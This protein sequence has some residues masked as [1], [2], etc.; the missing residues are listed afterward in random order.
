MRYRLGLFAVLLFAFVTFVTRDAFAQERTIRGTV[1][2]DVTGEPVSFVQVSVKGTTIGTVGGEDGT[3]TLRGAP[4]GAVTLVVQRIGYKSQEITVAADEAAVTVALVTDYL[5][6]EELI[7]TG[8]ATAIEREIAPNAVEHVSGERVNELPQQTIDQALQGRV[9][10]AV[11]ARNQG[12]PGGGLQV[13][14]RGSSSINAAAEPLYVVDGVLVSNA[15]IPSNQNVLT[16]ASGGSNPSLDQDV[17]QNRIADLNMQDIESI[18]ILKGASAAAIYGSKASNGVVIITTKRGRV[19]PAQVNASFQGGFFDLRS[20]IGARTFETQEE[21]ETA[22]GANAAQFFQPGRTFD[23]EGLLGGRNEF[24]WEASG[25]V[26][27]GAEGGLSYFGSALWKDD[28][29]IIQNTGFEKQSAR[30]NL[31][32]QLGD[33]RA[34]ISLNMNVIHSDAARSITN[35][36]NS[37]AVSHFMVLP[38]TPNFIDLRQRPDG[39]WPINVF[40]PGGVN[41]LQTAALLENDEIVWRMIASANL[42]VDVLRGEKNSF[43]IIAPLGVDFFNQRNRIFSP[44]SLN[45]ES[46]DGQLGTSLLSNTDNINLNM[47][48]NGIW[49][50]QASGGT[51]F[52]TAVGLQFERRE[53]DTSRLVGENLTG[54]KNK[55]DAATLVQIRENKVEVEDFGFY[56]QEEILGFN[57]R[58]LLTGMVR[59]DQSSADGNPDKVFI[60][61]K[62]ATS[63]RIPDAP[64]FLDNVKFRG[65][66]GQTGNQPLC[67]LEDGCQKFTSLRLDQNIEGIPGINLENTVGDPN[68]DPERMSE[69]EGG[70][71]LSAYNGRATLE[72]TGYGQIITNLILQRQIAEST[73]FNDLFFNGGKLRNLG[74][75]ASLG[76]TPVTSRNLTWVSR[77]SFFLNRSKL[78]D[79][80]VPPFRTIGFGLDLGQGFIME[81][82]SITQIA[83]TDPACTAFKEPF[84]NCLQEGLARNGDQNPDFTLNFSNDITLGD[85]RFF[86]LFE[87]R[88]GQDVINLT[89]LLY[90]LVGQNSPDFPVGW[91]FGRLGEFNERPARECHPDCNAA[92]RVLGFLNGSALPYTQPGSFLKARE[93][94]VSYSLPEKVTSKLFGG[95]F[96]RVRLRA[97]ARDLFAITNYDGLDPEVSNFGNQQVSRSIDVAPFPPSRSFFFGVDVGL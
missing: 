42:D 80:P 15:A 93:I 74:F 96:N 51:T 3:F 38:G 21:A 1:T 50:Y 18:E 69:F 63:Y 84:N 30:I 58:F 47:G 61:P 85:F 33:R 78:L 36:G 91:N 29:G 19:G 40:V 28:E 65:A 41:P 52:T 81:G 45:F 77:T 16:A 22:F 54:G 37:E 46:F 34:V 2:D 43:K 76:V 53:L 11:I 72:L 26:S 6:V 31:E 68:L 79:L 44:P 88:Q 32:T 17:L 14:I 60:Y 7:V 89:Q 4:A 25:S 94:S 87:W 70:V 56:I 23:Q 13:N 82:Q 20:K 90:D 75:E 12:A 66:F 27:G 8:R 97:A 86:A 71:D 62:V 39:S 67:D 83:G 5:Q 24:S 57:D 10:G 9:T 64:G 49:K 55:L 73:G 92:E 48:A 35:N 95:F 59:F